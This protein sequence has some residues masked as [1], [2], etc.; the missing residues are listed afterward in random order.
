[1]S[2]IEFLYQIKFIIVNL[3]PTFWIAV[4]IISPLFMYFEEVIQTAITKLLFLV[5]VK[6]PSKYENVQKLIGFSDSDF[7]K[8]LA[9]LHNPYE[10]ENTITEKHKISEDFL[11]ETRGGM[12]VYNELSTIILGEIVEDKTLKNIRVDNNYFDYDLI[13]KQDFTIKEL[14][15]INSCKSLDNNKLGNKLFTLDKRYTSTK[16][17]KEIFRKD[18]KIILPD[19]FISYFKT[20]MMECESHFLENIEMY[21]FQ[22]KLLRNWTIFKTIVFIPFMFFLSELLS[23]VLD[24]FEIL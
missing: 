2:F 7:Y 14:D 1:M 12:F 20:K 19:E 8:N 24:F 6:F 22:K 9:S 18:P 21:L 5:F 15:L 4:I 10:N 11:D 17:R 16:I 13:Y 3:E 23:E